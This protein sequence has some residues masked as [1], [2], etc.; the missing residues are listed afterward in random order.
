M[1][2]IEFAY[3]TNTTNAAVT[4]LLA[5]LLH[6]GVQLLNV[7]GWRWIKTMFEIKKFKNFVMDSIFGIAITLLYIPVVQSSPV[8][9]TQH[10]ST[11]R[12]NVFEMKRFVGTIVVLK[13]STYFFLL[14]SCLLVLFLSIVNII[15]TSCFAKTHVFP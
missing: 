14:I 11:T 13:Y 10:R 6:A 5:S 2:F 9:P 3:S 8:H 4:K 15:A 12:Y 1:H 7:T